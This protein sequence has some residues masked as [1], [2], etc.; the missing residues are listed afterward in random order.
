MNS[1]SFDTKIEWTTSISPVPYPDA[2]RIMEQRI[3]DIKLGNAPELIWCLQHPAILTAGTSANPNDLL[4]AKRFEVFKTGRGGQ[5]TYHGPGQRVVYVMLN[6]DKRGRDIRG[7][8]RQLEQWIIGS[9]SDFKIAARRYDERVGVWVD[10]KTPA[11]KDTEAKIAA[12]GIRIRRW[13]SFHGISINVDPDLSHYQ[14][15]VPCGISDFG[16]TSLADLGKT[17]SMA[18]LDSALMSGFVAQF[19]AVEIVEPQLP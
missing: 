6:L 19:G 7:F 2:L 11:G 3:E 14:A 18:D 12:I 17:Q 13:V 8:V 5:Y 10:K 4:Q 1:Y 16:V 15:I 9:L